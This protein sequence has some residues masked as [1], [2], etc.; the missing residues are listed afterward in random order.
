M[1]SN[2]AP[3]LSPAFTNPRLF[4]ARGD[5]QVLDT[6]AIQAA[7]DACA[8]NGGGTVFIPAGRYLT[9]TL[10]FRDNTTL[11]LDF[12]RYPVG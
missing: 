7:I 1:S 11:Y 8:L 2:L 6:P 3:A 4:G 5:G 9:G 12:R 10:F